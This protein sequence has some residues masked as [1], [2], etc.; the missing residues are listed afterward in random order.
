MWRPYTWSASRP[1]GRSVW[2]AAGVG[3]QVD[4]EPCGATGRHSLFAAMVPNHHSSSCL[5]DALS[6]QAPDRCSGHRRHPEPAPP[7]P[8]PCFCLGCLLGHLRLF[9][10]QNSGEGGR[11]VEPPSAYRPAAARDPFS[12]AGFPG[13]GTD[14]WVRTSQADSVTAG[15]KPEPWKVPPQVTLL[16]PWDGAVEMGT[17]PIP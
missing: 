17:L 9:C 5:T 15:C 13:V 6:L 3:M 11:R 2:L 7:C 16:L 12:L 8:P 10:I 1:G 14:R 4:P